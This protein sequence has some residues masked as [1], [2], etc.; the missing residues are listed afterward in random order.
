[1]NIIIYDLETDSSKTDFLS[2]LEFGAILLLEIDIVNAP[3]ITQVLPGASASTVR[4]RSL[5]S[6]PREYGSSDP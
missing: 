6:K 4:R 2:I 3:E 5:T 1:M